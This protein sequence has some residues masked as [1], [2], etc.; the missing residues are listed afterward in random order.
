M[1]IW[2]RLVRFCIPQK[3]CRFI[4]HL[5]YDKDNYYTWMFPVP[6]KKEK[7]TGGH[8]PSVQMTYQ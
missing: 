8:L 1:A 3:S 2:S 4:Y 7:K 6:K 5:N